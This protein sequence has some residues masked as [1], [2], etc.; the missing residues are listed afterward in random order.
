MNKIALGIDSIVGQLL[1][2]EDRLTVVDKL[3]Q[4]EDFFDDGGCTTPFQDAV[5]GALGDSP[6]NIIEIRK[7]LQ[8]LFKEAEALPEG[9]AS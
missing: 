7:E 4:V 2:M 6:N 8:E 9:G 5:K 1:C 3:C